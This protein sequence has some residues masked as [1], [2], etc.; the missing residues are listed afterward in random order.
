[1]RAVFL[2]HSACHGD[3][4]GNHLA[5]KVQA[6]LQ[7]G[8][9]VTVCVESQVRLHPLVAPLAF[10]VDGKKLARADRLR[11]LIERA[12]LIVAEYG[13]DY[14][15]LDWLPL[16]ATQGKTIVLDYHGVT[17]AEYALAGQKEALRASADRRSICTWADAIVVHSRFTAREL[18]DAVP[19]VAARIQV[20]PCYVAPCHGARDPV[21]PGSYR[22][23]SDAQ[24]HEQVHFASSA[25]RDGPSC[26]VNELSN[27]PAVILFVGRVARNKGLDTLIRALA[28][29]GPQEPQVRLTIVGD[30]QDIYAG[31]RMELEELA[32]TL[33]QAEAVH[34]TGHVSASQLQAWYARARVLVM[35]SRH[36]GFGVPVV[37]AMQRGLP[38]VVARAGALP[39]T[40]GDAGLS[41]TPDDPADLARMLRSVL[42][43]RPLSP[44]VRLKTQKG[45]TA[46][47][48]V[49]VITPRW[50]PACA[51]GAER[52]LL[53]MAHALADR[54]L[55][56][57]VLTTCALDP[58]HPANDLAPTTEQV[59]AL[60]VRRFPVDPIDQRCYLQAL[61]KIAQL[62]VHTPRSWIALYLQNSL[63]SQQLVQAL[64]AE[65]NLWDALIV[66]PYLSG[67]TYDIAREFGERVLIVPCFHDEPLAYLPVWLE[68][69]ACVGGFLFHSRTEKDFATERLG[70]NHPNTAVVGTCIAT[71]PGDGAAGCRRIGSRYVLYCGRISA[72]KGC[73][74]LLDWVRD[75]RREHAEG[76]HFV[77]IG[78]RPSC[79]VSSGHDQGLHFL[80]FV[81]EKDKRDLLAGAEALV[82]LSRYESLSLATLEA[83][84]QGVPVIADAECAVM[85]EHAAGG[86]GVQLLSTRQQFVATLHRLWHDAAWRRNLG[87]QGMDYVGKHFADRESFGAHVLGP[88]LALRHT[89]SELMSAKGKERALQFRADEVQRRWVELAQTQ[90]NLPQKAIVLRL[91]PVVA[92]LAAVPGEPI[93][94]MLRLENTGQVACPDRGPA[95][96]V[97][98]WALSCS[99]TGSRVA[100]GQV[101]LPRLLAPHDSL[102]VAVPL[103][104]LKDPGPYRLTADVS[105]P[106]P[107]V[108]ECQPTSVDIEIRAHD[109]PAH[110][111]PSLAD[112]HWL[113]AARRHLAE[114]A[115]RACLPDEYRDVTLGRLAPLKRWIKYKLLNNFK[116]AYVDVLA[117][118]QSAFNRNLVECMQKA[119]EA[120]GL[121]DHL[122]HRLSA[123]EKRCRRQHRHL[124]KLRQALKCAQQA[125][126][127]GSHTDRAADA[128]DLGHER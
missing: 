50:G 39:E 75:Y 77:F 54:G 59:G 126:T 71:I 124:H 11:A 103:P 29:L 37:E 120:I 34:F 27:Q 66:G 116:R 63:R 62:G 70:L 64:A 81:P 119:L 57:D 65:R 33:G 100:S 7:A 122:L 49:A 95:R 22:A 80:G 69:Y 24:L 78:D 1:M 30:C 110:M 32:E 86:A 123:L 28:L 6:L 15:L 99:A 12:D 108:V 74:R 84:A 3:A 98:N 127:I 106:E 102:T 53:L 58:A 13:L 40:L 17:P 56:V 87:R 43:Q 104:N 90:P 55:Q 26:H 42:S 125:R 115:A 4:I 44:G 109:G 93:V 105:V 67:L 9:E 121:M 45:H 21:T 76:Y 113:D 92:Q 118:Q 112:N 10:E 8:W 41:F 19:G 83:L 31:V 60:S 117:H 97:V 46:P 20:I 36:E 101:L 128:S 38:V 96:A 51:G 16:W 85:R 79:L 18:S 23:Q 82:Q 52:S 111:C 89:W 107:L 35:P 91:S 5:G 68:A 94:C 88:I 47:L 61:E 72:E 114:A 2:S 14:S 48:R 73:D 25:E